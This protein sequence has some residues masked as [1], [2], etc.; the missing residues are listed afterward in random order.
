[1]VRQ[2]RPEVFLTSTPSKPWETRD[3][4]IESDPDQWHFVVEI[5]NDGLGHLRFGDG[6]LAA[7][8]PAGMRFSATYRTGNGTAGNVG[9]E[10]ISPFVL[11]SPLSGA[12]PTLRDPP[13]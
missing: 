12:A 2:S 9:A 6:V 8:P 4:L 3:D 7:Q 11:D 5:D 13:A 10:S 1:D